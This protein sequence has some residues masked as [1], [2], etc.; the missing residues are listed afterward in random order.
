MESLIII[1]HLKHSTILALWDELLN[2]PFPVSSRHVGAGIGLVAT[3]IKLYLCIDIA[4][5]KAVAA[6][7]PGFR[8]RI[9]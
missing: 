6:T 8:S 5:A 7:A 2:V 1:L 3:S 9:I 4:C